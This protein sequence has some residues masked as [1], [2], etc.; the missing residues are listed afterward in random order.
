MK[1]RHKNEDLTDFQ[2]RRKECN[3]KRRAKDKP[4][5]KCSK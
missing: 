4:R 1:K 5:G 3:A 2:A